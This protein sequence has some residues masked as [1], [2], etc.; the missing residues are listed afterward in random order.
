MKNQTGSEVK[1]CERESSSAPSEKN[2]NQVVIARTKELQ[3]EFEKTATFYGVG[4]VKNTQ[5]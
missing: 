1:I 4:M 3:Y 2:C 5:K